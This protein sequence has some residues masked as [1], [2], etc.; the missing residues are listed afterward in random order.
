MKKC[1]IDVEVNKSTFPYE[2]CLI[3]S[4]DAD[5]CTLGL[6]LQEEGKTKEDCKYWKEE[7]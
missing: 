7:E 5:G 6:N 2:D 1:Y 4:D 3:D